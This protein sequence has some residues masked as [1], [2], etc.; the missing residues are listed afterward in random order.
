[1]VNRIWHVGRS[2]LPETEHGNGIARKLDAK[3]IRWES[4]PLPKL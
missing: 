1:M 3:H 4:A 2:V